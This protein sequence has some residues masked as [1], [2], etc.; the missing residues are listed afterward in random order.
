LGRLP[1]KPKR[2]QTRKIVN[3]GTVNA[4]KLAHMN[5]THVI[6]AT[7][8]GAQI[9]LSLHAYIQGNYA[10]LGGKVVVAQSS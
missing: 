2:W 10:K 8:T 6:I 5:T 4:S 7:S 3:N 9:W 1:P